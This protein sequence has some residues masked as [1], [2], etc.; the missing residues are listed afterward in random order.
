M[1]EN[2]CRK[3]SNPAEDLSS[4]LPDRHSNKRLLKTDFGI[5]SWTTENLSS[6]PKTRTKLVVGNTD[7]INTWLSHFSIPVQLG[8]KDRKYLEQSRMI[9]SLIV[10]VNVTLSRK[11]QPENRNKSKIFRQSTRWQ[12]DQPG[13][14]AAQQTLNKSRPRCHYECFLSLNQ[15][16][17]SRCP[18]KKVTCLK[19]SKAGQWA[20]VCKSTAASLQESSNDELETAAVLCSTGQP[21]ANISV[22][23]KFALS[24]EQVEAMLDMWS[25][26]YFI[27]APTAVKYS[28]K[29]RPMRKVTALANGDYLITT[30]TTPVNVNKT[31]LSA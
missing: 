3:K 22:R 4:F 15:Q 30:G 31:L 2:E 9:G 25:T 23:L 26:C 11:T 7:F 13:T 14:T 8:G 21:P 20:S 6:W 1:M 28:L 16:P 29:I 27:C 12:A 24:S 19:C 18:A 5:F 10:S 17:R